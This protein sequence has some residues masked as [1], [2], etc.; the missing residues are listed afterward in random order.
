LPALLLH[1]GQAYLGAGDAS[2]KSGE[3]GTSRKGCYMN[4]EDDMTITMASKGMSKEA[5]MEYYFRYE[6]SIILGDDIIKMF[7]TTDDAEKY[8]RAAEDM[9]PK[10]GISFEIE[11]PTKFLGSFVDE[12]DL[13]HVWKPSA[14]SALQKVYFPERFKTAAAIPLSLMAKIAAIFD[15]YPSVDKQKVYTVFFKAYQTLAK[16]HTRMSAAHGEAIASLP[17]SY[18]SFQLLTADM[19]Q[20][21]ENYGLTNDF[22]SVDEILNIFG[23]GLE[24]DV[25]MDRLGLSSLTELQELTSVTTGMTSDNILNHL[26]EN[27]GSSNVTSV[28]KNARAEVYKGLLD[29][30]NATL[31]AGLDPVSEFLGVTNNLVNNASELGL[32]HD[33]GSYA[34]SFRF[35]RGREKRKAEKALTEMITPS[36]ETND[37]EDN[38]GT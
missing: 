28:K 38:V 12:K 7:P 29:G 14:V 13:N 9:G 36:D 1:N 4:A 21:P 31:T 8:R 20:N 24:S 25:S 22:S 10:M 17:A 32:R 19:M 6:P 30:Y 27:L 18:R 33:H 26:A 34:F 35:S 16:K 37:T 23:H 5:L 15:N 3:S 11:K 2:L